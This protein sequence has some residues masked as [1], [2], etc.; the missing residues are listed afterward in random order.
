MLFILTELDRQISSKHQI[1]ISLAVL[2]RLLVSV[3]YG[4]LLPGPNNKKPPNPKYLPVGNFLS[5]FLPFMVWIL[6]LFCL[7]LLFFYIGQ[8]SYIN[9]I[10]V[11]PEQLSLVS[12]CSFFP[13]ALA[14]DQ[15]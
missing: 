5:N 1:N 11:I 7:K 13:V 3:E 6:D 14:S 2:T 10:S 9:F 8:Q 12:K 15:E 4:C